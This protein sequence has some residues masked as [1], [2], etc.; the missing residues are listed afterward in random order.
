MPS[1]P[2]LATSLRFVLCQNSVYVSDFSL[3]QLM[4]VPFIR[5]NALINAGIP[6][7]MFGWATISAV[8]TADNTFTAFVSQNNTGDGPPTGIFFTS[9]IKYPSCPPPRPFYHCFCQRPL[10]FMGQG[11][12]DCP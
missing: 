7:R 4:K 2:S 6:S 12:R 5:I 11:F 9:P 3:L 10:R 8:N 1:F